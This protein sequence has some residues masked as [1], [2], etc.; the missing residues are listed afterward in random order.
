MR[1]LNSTSTQ[2]ISEKTIERREQ[3]TNLHMRNCQ[4]V[5]K[6]QSNLGR[7]LRY[8]SNV[9][10]VALKLPSSTCIVALNQEDLAGIFST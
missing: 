3:K 2:N 6:I 5:L 8:Y 9:R 7:Y 10:K 1:L 4:K